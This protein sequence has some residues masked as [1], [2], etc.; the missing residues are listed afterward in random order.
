MKI[1]I[2]KLEENEDII[3]LSE[4][5][6]DALSACDGTR[7]TSEKT[8]SAKPISALQIKSLEP[9]EP[10][11]SIQESLS[12]LRNRSCALSALSKVWK[13]DFSITSFKSDIEVLASELRSYPTRVRSHEAVAQDPN[14]KRITAR[15]PSPS[16]V[17]KQIPTL[18]G[19][20]NDGIS[21]NPFLSAIIASIFFYR[22]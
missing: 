15:Y 18:A 12:E 19:L 4:M 10:P 17:Q 16:I 14:T 7:P 13:R 22:L 8:V 1:N 11:E 21:A 9:H 3:R 5:L 2:T 20:Y 6:S